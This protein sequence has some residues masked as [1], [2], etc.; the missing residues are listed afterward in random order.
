MHA[1]E[2]PDIHTSSGPLFSDNDQ[3]LRIVEQH[4]DVMRFCPGIGWLVYNGK[5]WDPSVHAAISLARKSARRR[6]LDALK[7]GD[8]ET[9]NKALSLE[10]AGH[11]TGALKLAES[12]ERVHISV[13]ALDLDPWKLNVN[14]G[15]L[16]LKTGDLLPHDRNDLITKLAPVD[17][18][19]KARHAAF[20]AYLA[21]IDAGVAG[22]SEFLSRALGMALSGDASAEVLSLLQGDGGAGKTTITDSFA[23]MLGDYAVKL[24]IAAFMLSKHGRAP[25]AA[26]PDIVR[27]RG[28]RFAFAAEGDVAAKLDAGIIKL[29][30][31]NELVSA[32]NLW[33]EPIEFR[34]TWKLWLVSNYDPKADSD[35]S[36]LWRRIIKIQ[37][38]AV[39]V[40]KRDPAIKRFM[41]TDPLCR[42]AI[43]AWAVRGCLDWQKRGGGRNGLA[44]P[45]EVDACTAAYRLG[46]DPLT[47]WAGEAGLTFN[48]VGII[49]VKD[50]RASYE[51]WCEDAG[52]TPVLGR[53]FNTWLEGRG[54]IRDKR[55]MGSETPV[56]WVGITAKSLDVLTVLTF[57]KGSLYALHGESLGNAGTTRTQRTG[58]TLS[59]EC[60]YTDVIK[61]CE[62]MKVD[63]MVEGD[64]VVARGIPNDANGEELEKLIKFHN[65]DLGRHLCA[66]GGLP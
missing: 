63:L 64:R 6:V 15:T 21:T 20:D 18:D 60:S 54:A 51:T 40:E 57:P 65:D 30:T 3:G 29:L 48:K 53:R 44:V 25:G 28:A 46:Q 43:L 39:P 62:S 37:F 16:D 4:R 22:M 41:T 19:P 23:E 50:L 36:G 14:N 55:R 8:R 32:R 31:G 61:C 35:D 26:S 13:A 47:M 17:Y 56:V 1:T 49:R 38:P 9:L 33:E 11:I 5:R 42:A 45:Q 34:A 66:I 24:P 12:D 52:F 7:T 27:L 2:E 58:S 59:E 10:S